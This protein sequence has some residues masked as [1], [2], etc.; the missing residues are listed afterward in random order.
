MEEKGVEIS[1]VGKI[2]IDNQDKKVDQLAV[3]PPTHGS[4]SSRPRKRRREE[5]GEDSSSGHA[6]KKKHIPNTA[7]E[8]NIFFF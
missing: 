1:E 5:T 4:V 6:K 8:V 3:S 2:M 7:D